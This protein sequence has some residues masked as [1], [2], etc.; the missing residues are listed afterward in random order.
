MC[1]LLSFL[2]CVFIVLFFRI[3]DKL[4]YFD[5]YLL[6]ILVLVAVVVMLSVFY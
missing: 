5:L 4:M 1:K 6:S 2:S 3:T